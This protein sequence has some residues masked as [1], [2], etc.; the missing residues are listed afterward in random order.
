VYVVNNL[1][2]PKAEKIITQPGSYDGIAV[3]EDG[4]KL[5][6]SNWSPAGVIEIDLSTKVVKKINLPVEVTGPADFSLWDDKLIIPDL[7]KSRVITV[8]AP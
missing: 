8:K 3:S 5:Y 2:V 7:V 4:S 1:K 6:V